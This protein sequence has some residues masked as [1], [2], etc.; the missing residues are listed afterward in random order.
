M[1]ADEPTRRDFMRAGIAAGAGLTLAVYLPGCSPRAPV[2][3]GHA[4][5]AQRLGP[6][7]HR[8]RGHRDRGQVRNGPGC[9]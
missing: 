1:S 4:V 6:D 5:R 2:V 7:R 9:A 8:W 3:P